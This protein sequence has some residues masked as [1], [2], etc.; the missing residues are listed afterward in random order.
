MGTIYI[1]IIL[2]C[3]VV[4][5]IYDKRSSSLMQGRLMFLRYTTIRQLTAAVMGLLLM[6][7]TKHHISCD[8]KTVLISAFS[9]VMLAVNMFCSIYA[10]KHGMVALVSLF[11]SAGL[12]VPCLAG[13]FMFGI[14]IYA[15]QWAG[16]GLFFVAAYLMIASSKKIFGEFSLKT[17]LLLIG[18]LL[19]NGGTMLGQQMF[20]Q[21]VPNGDVALFSMLMFGMVGALMLLCV[22]AEALVSKKTPA[23]LPRGLMFCAVILALVV[24]VINQFATMATVIV[25]P[26]ILFT[27]INGGSTIIAAIVAA[28]M[29]KEKLTFQSGVGVVLGIAALVI[30]KLFA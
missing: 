17:F 21:Y 11:S 19:S 3:R 16:L 12:I 8:V 6:I 13:V 28:V 30:I 24:F 27:F 2:L 7:F 29:F 23:R 1:G 5:H 25:P 20:T 4:Q 9:G 18:A 15:M 14:P 26:V 10:M 22:S